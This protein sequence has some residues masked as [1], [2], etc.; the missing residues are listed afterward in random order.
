[1][2]KLIIILII[3]LTI[4]G[5]V[6][7]KTIQKIEQEKPVYV[8]II[9]AYNK[10]IEEGKREVFQIIRREIITTGQLSIDI[11]MWDGEVKNMIL[12]IKQ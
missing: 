9:A 11:P 7:Y 10:G 4:A 5:I 8:G 3:I 12:I 6:H 1:M 2:N